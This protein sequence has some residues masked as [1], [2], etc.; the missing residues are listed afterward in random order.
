MKKYILKGVLCLG[1]KRC[2]K[3]CP[4][5]YKMVGDKAVLITDQSDLETAY[6]AY[7][8]CPAGAIRVVE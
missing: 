3:T 2:V 7:E 8:D 6:M 4:E 5:V 1:C